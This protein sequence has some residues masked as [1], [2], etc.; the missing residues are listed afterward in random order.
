MSP[1]VPPDRQGNELIRCTSYGFHCFDRCVLKVRV[2]DGRIVSVEP[3]DTVH[4]GTAR[5]GEH[6]A[7]DLS[8]TSV[9]QPCLVTNRLCSVQ[10]RQSI[11]FFPGDGTGLL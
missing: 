3:D 2:R 1:D 9:V 7:D 4:P 11:N 5:E 6:P 8:S 10:C